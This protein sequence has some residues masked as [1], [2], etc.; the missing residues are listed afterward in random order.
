[1]CG[2]VGSVNWGDAALFDR[3]IDVQQ[4]RGPDDRGAWHRTQPDGTTV[5]LGSRRL[6]I[7]D[8]SPA[9]H[10]PM[11]TPDGTATITYNG[12]IYNYHELRRELESHGYSFRSTSDTEVVLNMYHWLGPEGIRRLNGMFA[13]AIWDQRRERLF[14]ARDHLGIKP[15]YYMQQGEQF[16]FA[17]EI[18]SLLMLP[19]APRE[20]DDEAL[21]Q[22]L[23]FLWVPDPLTMFHG[24]YKLP[25]G[26]YAIFQRGRLEI[27]KYWDL[28][29]PSAD[30]HFPAD[31]VALVDEVRQRF[32]AAVAS[33]LRSDM[34]LG[35]FLSAGLDSSSIV[36]SMAQHSPTPVRTFTI[37]FPEKYRKG[38]VTIDDPAVARRT[39]AHFGCQHR[40]IVVE[41]DVASLLP[42]LTWHMDEPVADPAIITAYLVCREA[43]KDVTVLLSG[44]GGDELFAGYRKH[45]AHFLAAGYRRVPSPLRRFLIEPAVQ[46]L[47]AMRDSWLKGYVRLAKKMVRSGSLAPEDRFILDSVYITGAQ[48]KE[49]CSADTLRRFGGRDPHNRHLDY[50]VAVRHAD[51]LNR[52][53]YLDTKAF[54][55]SLNLTYNDKMSMAN[56]VEVRVP[57]LDWPFVQW[58]A[59]NVPPRLKLRGNRAKHIFR[60]AMRGVLPDEVLRQRKAGFGAPADYWLANDLREMVDDLLSPQQIAS[61]GLFRPAAVQQLIDQQRT[62]RN[63][64]SM[65]LWQLLTLEL[66]QRT[67]LDAIPAAVA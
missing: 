62:G 34:P 53:L 54:M 39:A 67:F 59:A 5:H 19:G 41:P 12:E 16:A 65:Q 38:E 55:V 22:Y 10:M 57:F 37:T 50:F 7:V 17:S 43:R 32:D 45:R 1:M 36:A 33:Q 3:M 20:I 31:E 21:Q 44:V 28:E 56:S 52:M 29:F 60:E 42:D 23:T 13:L 9:G 24:I 48:R 11:T 64:W 27:Q 63:D 51:F 15:V 40:E 49:L 6:A 4:H 26:H 47:P 14:V 46:S 18:K 25:A 35:A 8:L 66:W 58:V 2:I 61:R 30:H